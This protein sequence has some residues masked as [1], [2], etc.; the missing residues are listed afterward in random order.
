[1]SILVRWDCADRNI[2]YFAIE[3]AWTWPQLQEQIDAAIDLAERPVPVMVDLRTWAGLPGGSL[4]LPEN[5]AQARQLIARSARRQTPIIVVGA[6]QDA[7]MLYDC[8]RMIDS[9]VGWQ[10]YFTDTPD[11]ARDFLR[12]NVL[13]S[14]PAC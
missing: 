8:L 13:V 2:L 5:L 7:R 14:R 9:R 10:V 1:M 4:F 3:G 11:E 6:D 12:Q